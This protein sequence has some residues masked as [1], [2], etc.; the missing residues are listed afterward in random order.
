MG[1]CFSISTTHPLKFL[2]L[3]LMLA[4]KP[5]KIGFITL[6][7]DKV[8]MPLETLTIGIGVW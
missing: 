3:S 1:G 5:S 4:T 8:S 6:R 7:L 2:I